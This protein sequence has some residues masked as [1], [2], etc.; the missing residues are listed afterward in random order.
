M[1]RQKAGEA[2]V[3]REKVG[4]SELPVAVLVKVVEWLCC[5]N[6]GGGERVDHWEFRESVFSLLLACPLMSRKLREEERFQWVAG[7]AR[8]ECLDERWWAEVEDRDDC[9]RLTM[10]SGELES[11]F[12]L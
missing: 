4:V 9:D 7:E 3:E 11:P 1:E 10:N 2:K 12:G 6:S 8:R 5:R